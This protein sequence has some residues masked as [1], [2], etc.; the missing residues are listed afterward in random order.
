MR[1]NREE[2]AR[3]RDKI[4]GVAARQFREFGYDGVGIAGLME[5]AGRTHGGFYK[6]F[7]D[8]DALMVE[9]TAR[10]LS[11]NKENWA[12]AMVKAPDD[13][14][15]ALR[16]WYLSGAH[17]D[18]PANGCAYAALAAEA[19]RHSDALGAAFETGLEASIAQ[20]S[21][22]LPDGEDRE[23]AIRVIAQLIGSLIL[24]RAVRSPSLA[25]EI[26]QSGYGD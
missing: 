21:A 10:A 9:A 4:V 16:R 5:A 18:H 6:L 19:P 12:E 14:V 23:G 1:M 7:A 2:A 17:R 13:P 24:A 20:I 3:N 11:D 15:A 26:L 8:K 22:V 25:T